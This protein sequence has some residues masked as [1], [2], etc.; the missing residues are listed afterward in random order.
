MAVWVCSV[1]LC[2]IS[3]IKTNTSPI[4]WSF[5]NFCHLYIFLNF[6][7]DKHSIWPQ[8]LSSRETH[9]NS[10]CVLEIW[11]LCRTGLKF[12]QTLLKLIKSLA[13]LLRETDPNSS[14]INHQPSTDI[15]YGRVSCDISKVHANVPPMSNR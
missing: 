9:S 15:M 10:G 6:S 4:Y 12:L 5:K 11:W 13:C 14:V 2:K 3:Y 7:Y 8:F 1:P